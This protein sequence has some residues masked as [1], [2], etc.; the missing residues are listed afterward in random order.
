MNRYFV[1]TNLIDFLARCFH[2]TAGN[3]HQILKYKSFPVLWLA[4]LSLLR[5]NHRLNFKITLFK[6]IRTVCHSNLLTEFLLSDKSNKTKAEHFNN[7][8]MTIH[9]NHEAFEAKASV[10]KEFFSS[11]RPYNNRRLHTV[12]HVHI[13]QQKLSGTFS[14]KSWIKDTVMQI[15]KVVINDCLRVSKVLIF[16]SFYW[17]FS[18]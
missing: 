18:L 2:G 5:K 15:E 1:P 3:M 7:H 13:L 10:F 12:Q 4:L 8:N 6:K 17:L 11:S 14:K 9:Q 16:N